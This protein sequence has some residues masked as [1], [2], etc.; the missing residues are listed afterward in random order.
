VATIPNP[1]DFAWRQ[2]QAAAQFYNANRAAIEQAARL[3]SQIAP[4]IR[5]IEQ[6]APAI[7][8]V[9]RMQQDMNLA[10][11]LARQHAAFTAMIPAIPMPTEAELTETRDRMAELVPETEQER[12]QLAQQAIEIE[13]DP[14]GKKLIWQ[15][16]DWVNEAV[17]RLGDVVAKHP[18]EFGLLLLAWLCFFVVPPDDYDAAGLFC[19]SANAWVAYR[20]L[21]GK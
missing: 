19:A 16:T 11:I 18:T 15:L 13:A 1:D 8:V 9:Q 14:E 7:A 20:A 2:A 4:V 10:A 17:A 12:E 6:M 21:K 3:A 5:M